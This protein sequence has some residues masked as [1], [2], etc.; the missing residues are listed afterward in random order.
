[1]DEQ[2]Y[3]DIQARLAEQVEVP[4]ANAGYTPK[5]GDLVF[6]FDIQYEEDIGYVAIDV[7]TWGSDSIGVYVGKYPVTEPYV[8]GLFAFREGPLLLR[9]LQDIQQQ[10]DLSPNLLIVDGHGTAHPRMMG[11]ACWLGLKTQLPTIGLAKR[12]LVKYAGNLKEEVSST[13]P[14]IVQGKTVG[15]VLRTQ[16]GIRPVFVSPGH[17]VSLSNSVDIIMNLRGDYRHIDPIR[18]ADQAARKF[19]KNDIT[20]EMIVLNSSYNEK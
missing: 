20:T 15:H 6:T 18:R 13:L 16:E 2:K 3:L 5:I 11:V 19:A 7:L 12:S 10:T 14:I 17:L 1:M 4:T 9:C 8:P